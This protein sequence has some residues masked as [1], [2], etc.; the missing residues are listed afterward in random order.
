[1]TDP[2]SNYSITYVKRDRNGI[3]EPGLTLN[4]DMSV[5]LT[6]NYFFFDN[7]NETDTVQ[8]NTVSLKADP[9]NGH[10]FVGESFGTFT[11]DPTVN[12]Q[13][14]GI[15]ATSF[16]FNRTGIYEVSGYMLFQRTG[17]KSADDIEIFLVSQN[18]FDNVIVEPIVSDGGTSI[19]GTLRVNDLTANNTTYFF[20]FQV[21]GS[22]DAVQQ[23]RGG[24]IT[25]RYLGPI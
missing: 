16:V 4:D 6:S 3:L 13:S 5:P 19:H 2:I 21:E 8:N 10:F 23:K 24:H 1:M 12:G 11:Y 7:F 14:S 18:G 25:I 22:A 17:T 9:D 20:G 15:G